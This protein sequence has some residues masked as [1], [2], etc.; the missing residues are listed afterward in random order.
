MRRLLGEQL[1]NKQKLLLFWSTG[2][3]S[4][5]PVGKHSQKDMQ[6]WAVGILAPSLSLHSHLWYKSTDS[7]PPFVLLQVRLPGHPVREQGE[8]GGARRGIEGVRLE[9]MYRKQEAKVDKDGRLYSDFKLGP[10]G[11]FVPYP[12]PTLRTLL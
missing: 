8:L 11:Y 2:R 10:L 12:S 7:L 6:S 9:V 1:T 4:S 5:L 3:A